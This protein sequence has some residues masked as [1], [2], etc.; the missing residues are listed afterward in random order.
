MKFN[1]YMLSSWWP[2]SQFVRPVEVPAEELT[3]DVDRDLDVIFRYG[4]NDFQPVR[5]CCSVS[6]G[7]V[8]EYEG[9]H[10]VAAVG[11][12]TFDN[13]GPEAPCCNG[14]AFHASDCPVVLDGDGPN[15]NS[16]AND[17]MRED[18]RYER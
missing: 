11:F 8:I 18:G 2:G 12:K 5:G 10:E 7:D 16:R 14:H 9:L 6:V 17:R 13:K 15:P 1:V 3:G 4:Q